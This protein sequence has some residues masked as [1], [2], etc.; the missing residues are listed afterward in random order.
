MDFNFSETQE[1]LRRSAR[2][3][4]KAE[5]PKKLVKDMAEDEKGYPPELWHKTANLLVASRLFSTTT[6]TC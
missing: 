1:M 3:F 6:P 4:L 2:D 5:C